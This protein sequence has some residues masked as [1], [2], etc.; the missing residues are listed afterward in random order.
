MADAG[1]PLA[2]E[3]V[4]KGD[5]P[6]GY[7]MTVIVDPND[8]DHDRGLIMTK[9]DKPRLFKN[10]NKAVAEAERLVPK[11]KNFS[12]LSVQAADHIKVSVNG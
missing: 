4:P 7:Y 12:V 9:L 3:F 1:T 11:I 8:P 2:I 10:L 6:E 5:P